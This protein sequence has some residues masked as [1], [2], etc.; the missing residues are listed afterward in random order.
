MQRFLLFLATLSFLVAPVRAGSV[1]V[2]PFFN[3][4]NSP[5]LDWIGVGISQT[6]R[7][8]LGKH[9]ILVL[10][11]EDREEAYRR[12]SIRPNARL[13]RASV[14]KVA[15]ALDAGQVIYGEFNFTQV[16]DA[17]ASGS[18]GALLINAR[19][20]DMTRMRISAEFSERGPLEDLA[21]LES[22][23]GW[24]TLQFLAPGSAPS[25]EE[26]ARERP[27]VR[28]DA[29]ENYVR[30]LLAPDTNQAHR[31]FTQAARLDESF[32]QPCFELGRLYWGK[33]EYR[34]AAGWLARVKPADHQ[35]LK[36]SFLLGLCRFYSA[37]YEG[38]QAAFEIV[39]RSV[40]LNE[41]FNDLG[42]AQ[43]RRN[44]PDSLENF[45][46][47]L[48][49]D[50]SDP[51]YHFNVGYILWKNGDYTA[52]AES[53]RAVLAREPEDPQATLMLGRCLKKMGPRPGDPNSQGLE[54]LKHNYEERAFRE[55]QAALQTGA[56][57]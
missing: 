55:L 14:I 34:L 27:P 38:A 6:L 3:V 50:P 11:R 33:K 26:F 12:L 43:S 16:A 39:A 28:L 45:R 40:P 35:Y 17:A 24:Q 54:R 25:A 53:F 56:K 57:R 10:E 46:K 4:S 20:L 47:A 15:E 44:L 23:L 37:D 41:V 9:G 5:N 48:E 42:A 19:V 7:D 32:S 29:M 30:G 2:V 49:G 31:F 18:R 52:A 1:L 13:T 22:H 36:A 21:R 8:V 51:D